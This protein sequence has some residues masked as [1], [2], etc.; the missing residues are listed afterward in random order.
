M[1]SSCMRLHFILSD[2]CVNV[3]GRTGVIITLTHNESLNGRVVS[4]YLS[5]SFNSIKDSV[6][7]L[8]K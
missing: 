3:G 4:S 5:R 2:K 7:L 6:S 1:V 8:K